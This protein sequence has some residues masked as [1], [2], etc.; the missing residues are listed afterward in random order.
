[1]HQVSVSHQEG[2][3]GDGIWPISGAQ[4]LGLDRAQAAAVATLHARPHTATATAAAEWL[5]CGLAA[6][7][8]I[9]VHND[10]TS[11]TS[12][13][14]SQGLTGVQHEIPSC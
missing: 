14:A 2:T 3:H 13:T 6:L 10:R 11:T 12:L 9:P 4:P 7:V 5:G 8:V 1:M